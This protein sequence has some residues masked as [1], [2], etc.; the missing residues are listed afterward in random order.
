MVTCRLGQ[1]VLDQYVLGS[2]CRI[3]IMVD[4]ESRSR[5]IFRLQSQTQLY[6]A[7]CII[8][9]LVDGSTKLIQ[10]TNP[11]VTEPSAQ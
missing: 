2:L 9:S 11:P 3:E 1:S 5:F 8:G 7:Y 6:K 10:L 4:D